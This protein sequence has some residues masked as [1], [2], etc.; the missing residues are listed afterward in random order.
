VPHVAMANLIA[1]KRVVPELIQHDFTAENIVQEFV[2]LLPDGPARESMKIEL[3]AIRTAL[4]GHPAA[5][6]IA[7]PGAIERVAE[8]VLEVIGAGSPAA[9][10]A[11]DHSKQTVT[12][13]TK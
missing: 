5:E 13:P 1:G 8:V 3:G 6:G 7:K 9:S 12:S 10:A 11:A 2:R 4:R